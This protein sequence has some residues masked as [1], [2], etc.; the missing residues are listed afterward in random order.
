MSSMGNIAMFATDIMSVSHS[1]TPF[2]LLE[3]VNKSPD[4]S[5]NAIYWLAEFAWPFMGILNPS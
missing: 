1:M 5:A 2:C 3:P 4:S